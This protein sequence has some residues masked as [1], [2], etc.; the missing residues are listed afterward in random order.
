MNKKILF[1]FLAL[2]VLAF[3]TLTMQSFASADEID[4]EPALVEKIASKFNLNK[5]EVQKVF[6]EERNEMHEKMQQKNNER[7]S[8]LVTEGKITDTQKNLIQN[9]Q[10]ELKE[11]RVAN[12]DSFKDKTPEQRKTEMESKKAELD[13]WAKENGIDLQYL[14]QQ[15][16]V[17]MGHKGPGMQK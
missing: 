13:A 2:G 3:G 12:K 1:P 8:Q 15:L 11:Q 7:L 9:K 16:G 10:K 14:F 5:D 17:E 4:P 6:D